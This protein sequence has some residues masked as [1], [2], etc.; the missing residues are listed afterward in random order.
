MMETFYFANVLTTDQ[1]KH[2]PCD[3]SAQRTHRLGQLR[4]GRDRRQQ[5]SRNQTKHQEEREEQ[6]SRQLRRTDTVG[7]LA[8][9][10]AGGSSYW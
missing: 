1:R 3:R 6:R 10:V 4:F 2:R 9:V 7:G 5:E 8:R